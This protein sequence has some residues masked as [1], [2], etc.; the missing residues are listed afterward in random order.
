MSLSCTIAVPEPFG[1]V[2][3]VNDDP[4]Q[5]RQPPL[6]RLVRIGVEGVVAGESP[7]HALGV[8][9]ASGGGVELAGALADGPNH[10]GPPVNDLGAEMQQ[11]GRVATVRDDALGEFA[12]HVDLRGLHVGPLVDL[13][14]YERSDPVAVR[15]ASGVALALLEPRLLGAFLSA[16]E[17]PLLRLGLHYRTPGLLD[18]GRR[19]TGPTVGG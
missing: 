16:G 5:R 13:R 17:S 9:Q 4:V 1:E 10:V 19:D 2:Y 12:N 7:Q 14:R 6:D 18:I 3:R 11:V 15:R 8:V